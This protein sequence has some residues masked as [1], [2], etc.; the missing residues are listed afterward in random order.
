MHT[1]D[2]AVRASREHVYEPGQVS[3]DDNYNCRRGCHIG[4][5]Q[6]QDTWSIKFFQDSWPPCP[7]HVDKAAMAHVQVAT[8]FMAAHM[9]RTCFERMYGQPLQ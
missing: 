9:T 5:V 4:E 7:K 3:E 6:S 2:S 1:P 8:I